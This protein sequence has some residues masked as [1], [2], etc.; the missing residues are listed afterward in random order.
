[1]APE[2]PPAR[3]AC[4]LLTV[5]SRRRGCDAGTG[6][7]EMMLDYYRI[8]PEWITGMAIVRG[9]PAE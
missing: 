8:I 4:R 1:V 5:R 6:P 9:A 2:G 7:F 3:D